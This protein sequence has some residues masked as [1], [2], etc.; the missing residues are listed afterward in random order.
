MPRI[1]GYDSNGNGPARSFAGILNAPC[2]RLLLLLL[3]LLMAG[4]LFVLSFC[5]RRL[6]PREI[7]HA[8]AN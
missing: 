3:I 2:S 4:C 1:L 6:A 8:T 5:M 7:I